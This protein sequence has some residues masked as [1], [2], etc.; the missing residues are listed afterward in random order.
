MLSGLPPESQ[1]RVLESIVPPPA[2]RNPGPV[3][4][5]WF[6]RYLNQLPQ[7][8]REVLEPLGYYHAEVS[9]TQ[10][11]RGDR[12]LL[13]IHV[14][15][16]PAV[17]L[18]ELR[19][20]LLDERPERPE[21]A[22]TSFPLKG[23]DVLR[24]DLYEKGKAELIAQV[25]DQGF[26]EARYT[27]HELQVDREKN[28]ARILLE[29][30]AGQ[31]SRFGTVTFSGAEVYPERFLRRYLAFEQGEAFSYRLL[32][33]TQ[34]QLRDSDRFRKVLVVSKPDERQVDQVP[35]GIELEPRKR[36]S[37]RPGVGY[38]TDT[39]A[40]VSLRYLDYNA[41]QLGHQFNLDLLLAEQL[42]NY[43]GSYAFPGYRNLNT[44]LNLHGGYR[45]EQL[46]SYTNDY[47]FAEVE[48]TYGFAGGRIGAVF[49]RSQY[50]NSDISGDST[51]TGFL[52]PGVRYTEVQL[53]ESTGKSYGFHIQG[54]FRFSDQALL[55]ELSL[56]QLLGSGELF[57]SLPLRMS[58]TLRVQGAT[59]M[60]DNPFA[61]IPASL[62]FFAGGDRSVRGYAYQSLGPKDET[63]SVIG[64]KHL[65]SGSVELG[66][67]LGGNWGV[68]L[69]VDMGNAFDSWEDYT[70]E[71]GAG[72]GLRYAT[73]VGPLQ[74]DLASPVGQANLSP[75]LHVGIGFGW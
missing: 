34:K 42:Q 56:M 31:R 51:S 62:R 18:A 35:I 48:Q 61:E 1:Q 74:I 12:I 19:I 37:L 67:R 64:G 49:V 40:R 24:D 32:G 29:I 47:I 25:R 69:F 17:T 68:A 45:A 59:T 26:L 60:L 65:L 20:E 75:R 22:R 14:D 46:D 52:M 72:M 15:P 39:G 38:G 57:L 55:S 43:T 58:L 66:K 27:R 7:K 70:L 63:G 41:W 36:Y 11:V 30:S 3:N 6:A 8:I 10:D 28:Q 33:K 16:G 13:Q 21:L 4:R 5:M 44:G 71:T 9:T 23:G 73:P 50:E 53:P 2:L 54:E